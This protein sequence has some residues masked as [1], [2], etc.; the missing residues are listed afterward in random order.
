MSNCESTD[1]QVLAQV[2]RL[3]AVLGEHAI[4][5]L[6]KFVIV[7][8]GWAFH[9]NVRN[10]EASPERSSSIHGWGR[11][12]SERADYTQ[13][14]MC[15]IELAGVVGLYEWLAANGDYEFRFGNDLSQ[16]VH[17]IDAIAH[18]GSKYLLCESKGTTVFR[19]GP[20]SYLKRTK[21]YGRQLSWRWC[22]NRLIYL[23]CYGHT[24]A[25]FL[26]TLTPFI[27]GR[28][29]RALIVSEVA[30][31]ENGYLPT[32]RHRAW[33]EPELSRVD[34]LAERHNHDSQEKW[35]RELIVEGVFNPEDPVRDSPFFRL[36]DSA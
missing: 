8:Q 29:Q 20:L 33:L 28:A 19:G 32:Q 18:I 21:T 22:W 16:I 15:S 14:P 23:A 36:G 12:F 34:G 35:L 26:E 11:V 17:G 2:I 13:D 7:A 6:H 24:A 27:F 4:N 25:T 1:D 31:I 3:I 30:T 10:R 5:P 9:D